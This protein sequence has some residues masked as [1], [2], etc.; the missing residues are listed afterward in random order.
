MKNDFDLFGPPDA[1]EGQAFTFRDLVSVL[2]K[3]RWIILVCFVVVT[4]LVAVGLAMLPPTY[5]A[6]GKV[7]VK[8][9]QQ[10]NPSI[11]SGIAAYREPRD[12]DPVNRKLETEMEVLA[13]RELSERVV[14]KLNLQYGQVYHKPLTHLL[15]PVADLVDWAKVHLL[16]Y[17]EDLDAYG[18]KGTVKEFNASFVVQPLKSKSAETTSN[19]IQIQLKAPDGP[20]AQTALQHLLDEFVVLSVEQNERLARDAHELVEKDLG[21]AAREL[22]KAREEQ[23]KF[24]VERGATLS[25][26]Y[27]GATPLA[28]TNAKDEMTGNVT[29]GAPTAVGAMRSRLVQSELRLIELRQIFTDEDDNVKLMEATISTIKRRIESELRATAESEKTLAALDLDI[30][31]AELKYVDIRRKLEQIALFLKLSPAQTYNRQIAEPPLLPRSSEWK[32]SV[33]AG[34]LG[35]IGGLMLG[36]GIAG[37]REYSDHRLGTAEAV[38]RHLGLVPLAVVAHLDQDELRIAMDP[39]AATRIGEMAR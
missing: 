19:M 22:E 12:S 10:G 16:G 35:A 33:L 18:F 4:L 38:E 26:R 25:S 37:Y 15:R 23:R 31:S 5:V 29:V 7:L 6:E 21:L 8:T 3:H 32:K 27:T 17:P 36:L 2:F 11:F 34:V 28:P 39:G 9:E 30:K 1:A 24:I 20:T 14:R 13:T